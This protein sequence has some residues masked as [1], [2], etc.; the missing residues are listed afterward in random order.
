LDKSGDKNDALKHRKMINH[1]IKTIVIFSACDGEEVL[2]LLLY[3]LILGKSIKITF[4]IAGII[5]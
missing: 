2:V 3:T 1:E 4:L 5:I